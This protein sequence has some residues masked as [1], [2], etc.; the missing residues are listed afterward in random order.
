MDQM[1]LMRLRDCAEST[2]RG[3]IDHGFP[4]KMH[5]LEGMGYVVKTGKGYK[6]TR[7]GEE[8]LESDE[9]KAQLRKL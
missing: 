1:L 7:S 4:E 6:T 2:A 9:G 3:Y 8:F 5:K